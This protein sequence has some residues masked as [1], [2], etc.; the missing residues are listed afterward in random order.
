M[1][2]RIGLSTSEVLLRIQRG[3]TNA[4]RTT[5]SR[6]FREI[7]RAHVFTRF[8]A[9]LGILLVAVLVAN[10]PGD[11]LFGFVLLANSTIGVVQEWLA[12]RKLDA[13]ALLHAQTAHVF[14]D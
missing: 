11:G 8:N 9:V 4:T 10:S 6:T 1:T 5:T 2:E 12:K 3:Q 7:F 14:R 13:L